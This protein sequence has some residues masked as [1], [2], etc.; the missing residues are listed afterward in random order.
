V[1]SA[2]LVGC[3]LWLKICVSLLKYTFTLMIALKMDQ[4]LHAYDKDHRQGFK[5]AL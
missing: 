4:I 2:I 1:K 3:P 5:V